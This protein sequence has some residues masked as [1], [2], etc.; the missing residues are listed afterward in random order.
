MAVIPSP[1]ASVAT[2]ATKSRECTIGGTV[3]VVSVAVLTSAVEAAAVDQEARVWRKPAQLLVLV[4][5]PRM[6]TG[7]ERSANGLSAKERIKVS[8]KLVYECPSR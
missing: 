2:T 3:E 1:L 5:L 6:N 8:E 4:L 7:R